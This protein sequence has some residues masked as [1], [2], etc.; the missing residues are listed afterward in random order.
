[1]V[2]DQVFVRLGVSVAVTVQTASPSWLIVVPA[3][4]QSPFQQLIAAKSAPLAASPSSSPTTRRLRTLRPSTTC[5]S[6]AECVGRR[7]P[8][9]GTCPAIPDRGCQRTPG[10]LRRELTSPVARRTPR[11]KSVR[12]SQK[13]FLINAVEDRHR[14]LSDHLV[15]QRRDAQR[16]LPPSGFGNVH[17]SRG[18]ARYAPRC[19]RPCKSR[20]RS[21]SPVS[22]ARQLTPSA[23]TA[24]C[25]F[26]AKKLLVRSSAV[27]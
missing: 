19:T 20:I 18:W 11:P 3:F 22:Y 27:R 4:G 6:S 2:G 24:A 5:E 21:L 15:L 26:S 17:A 12:K 8:A 9:P 10:C 7:S 1:M 13:S 25:L 16:T 14:R 23:P